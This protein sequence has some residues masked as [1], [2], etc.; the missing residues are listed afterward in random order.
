MNDNQT[1]DLFDLAEA[2]RRR[3]EGVATVE[4]HNTEFKDAAR[5]EFRRWVR[6]MLPGQE[7][8]CEDFRIHWMTLS[9]APTPRHHNAWGGLFLWAKR[10]NLIEWSGN[11]RQMSYKKSHARN[12][13]LY[14]KVI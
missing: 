13:M 14:V 10:Q 9:D 7:F 2:R 6:D 3:D 4:D 5:A 11:M 8:N 12:T 1:M